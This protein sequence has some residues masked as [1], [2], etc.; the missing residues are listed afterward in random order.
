MLKSSSQS[1][2]EVASETQAWWTQDSDL[3]IASVPTEKSCS[4]PVESL[5]ESSK[6]LSLQE[7]A[8]VLFVLQTEATCGTR[9]FSL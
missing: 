2:S 9:D 7:E 5:M 8:E 3:G 1:D 6:D 4:S